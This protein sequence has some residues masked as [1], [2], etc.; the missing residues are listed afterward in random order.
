MITYFGGVGE[1][2]N[3]PK[4]HQLPMMLVKRKHEK[5]QEVTILSQKKKTPKPKTN[6][7]TPEALI[8]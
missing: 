4:E 7:K 6:K 1:E 5:I 2:E 3:L 8:N